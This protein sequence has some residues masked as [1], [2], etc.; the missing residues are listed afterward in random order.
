MNKIIK[1]IVTVSSQSV[2]TCGWQIDL[3]SS[4]TRD[5]EEFLISNLCRT[6]ETLGKFRPFEIQL[7]G[8][9]HAIFSANKNHLV[10]TSYYTEEVVEIT[11]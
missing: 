8:E 5:E 6:V 3:D 7:M 10:K 2:C 4:P 9:Y 11:Q 1:K